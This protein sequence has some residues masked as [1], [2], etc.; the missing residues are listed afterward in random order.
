MQA[1]LVPDFHCLKWW[2]NALV[3]FYVENSVSDSFIFQLLSWWFWPL[4]NVFCCQK[5]NKSEKWKHKLVTMKAHDLNILHGGYFWL[6]L[7]SSSCL[8]PP[9]NP[10]WRSLAVDHRPSNSLHLGLPSPTVSIRNGF[11]QKKI[12]TF[13]K[14]QGWWVHF[15]FNLFRSLGVETTS[16]VMCLAS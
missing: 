16:I 4:A 3:A 13:C 14:S 7:S 1:T 5:K 12:G 2:N 9:I 6:F 8:A 11:P 15:K 10:I